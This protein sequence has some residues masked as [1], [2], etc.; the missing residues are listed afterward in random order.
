MCGLNKEAFL[1]ICF[2]WDWI[3][4]LLPRSI[5]ILETA[6]SLPDSDGLFS[7][8]NKIICMNNTSGAED[9]GTVLTIG[10]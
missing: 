10:D 7:E 3:S 1:E 9:E 6:P 8:R 2:R 4:T 5:G